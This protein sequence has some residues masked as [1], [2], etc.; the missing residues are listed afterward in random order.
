MRDQAFGAV[1]ELVE[2]MGQIEVQRFAK[3]VEFLTNP[4]SPRVRTINHGERTN[5]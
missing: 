5:R 4:E 3:L 2:A 1:P